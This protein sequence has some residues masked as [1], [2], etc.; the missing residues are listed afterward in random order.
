M[1]NFLC[2]IQKVRHLIVCTNSVNNTFQGTK[3]WI[4]SKTPQ[5]GNVPKSLLR[6]RKMWTTETKSLVFP[7]DW[8]L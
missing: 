5:H 2:V 1:N 7:P 4:E 6:Q 8:Q 3:H